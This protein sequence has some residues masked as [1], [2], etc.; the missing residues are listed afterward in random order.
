MYTVR[1]IGAPCGMLPLVRGCGCRVSV[2]VAL[3]GDLESGG[4]ICVHRLRVPELFSDKDTYN[5]HSK[6]CCGYGPR[7]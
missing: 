2:G 7:A 1:R 6:V 4:H 3:I 5:R